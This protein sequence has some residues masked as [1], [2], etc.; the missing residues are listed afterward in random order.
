MP[1][2][3]GYTEAH[4]RFAAHCFNQTWALLERVGRTAEDDEL[5]IHTAHASLWHW[6]HREDCS[7]RNLSIGYWQLARI[8]AVTGRAAEARRYAE[9]C[10]DYSRAEGAFYLGYAYEAL[11]RAALLAGDAGQAQ[12]YLA[13]ARSQ[14]ELVGAEEE[15]AQLIADLDALGPAAHP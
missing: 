13:E 5:M 14:A 4:R 10:L 11:A 15:R 6:N 7:A 3:S 12:V 2:E 9:R 8:Y 1:N